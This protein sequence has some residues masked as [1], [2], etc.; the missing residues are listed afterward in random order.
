[1]LIRL[2]YE[3]IF[4][5]PAPAPMLLL[6]STHPS[7]AASLLR[8]D[9][10]RVEPE[11]PARGFRGPLRQPLHPR[12]RPGR[13][14]ALVERHAGR[15]LRPTRPRPPGRR[16][17]P[18]RGP[19]ARHAPLP[20]GQP[21]LRGGSSFARSPGTCSANSP[22]LGPGPGRLRL[23]P[24][25]RPLRLR[26]RPPHQDGLRRLHRAGRGLPRLHAPGHHLLPLPEH[27]GPLR[28]RLPRRHR[29]PAGRTPRWT[30]AP[31]SRCSWAAGGTRSTPGTTSRASAA[32]SWPT[33]G[34]P[35]T[36]P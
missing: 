5:A 9:R 23:G 2:G 25:Q 31:G 15:G 28:H 4:E 34:T 17:A 8:P 14:R 29:R 7:R 3:L 21:L 6:L 12:R 16:A 33:A 26:V 13:P 1:M 27:P 19:A 22:G 10:L 36:W 30:S 24:R 20:A 18:R 11:V 35:W 32:C